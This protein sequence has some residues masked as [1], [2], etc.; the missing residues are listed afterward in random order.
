MEGN[1]RLDASKV[2]LGG[3]NVHGC[4]Y[5]CDKMEMQVTTATVLKAKL[6]G[7]NVHGWKYGCDKMKSKVIA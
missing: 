2:K 7:L 1:C 6:G 4:K 3:L 5:A